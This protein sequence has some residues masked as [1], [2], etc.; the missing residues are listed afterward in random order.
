MTDEAFAEFYKPITH[1]FDKLRFVKAVR[2]QRLVRKIV[3]EV[4][5]DLYLG[6]RNPELLER[7]ALETVR[8]EQDYDSILV[9]IGLAILTELIRYIV[10]KLLERW[11]PIKGP[12][13]C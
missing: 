5:S 6:E 10:K 9:I 4:E 1:R 7:T 11:E 8:R 2:R 12:L 3:T 13:G